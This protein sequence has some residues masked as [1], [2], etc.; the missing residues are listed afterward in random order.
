[1]IIRNKIILFNFC[2]IEINLTTVTEDDIV[3]STS[4]NLVDTGTAKDDITTGTSNNY[5]LTSNTSVNISFR[6]KFTDKIIF[7]IFFFI[8]TDHARVTK[9]NVQ[10]LSRLD[11]IV[12]GTTP[13]DD[14]ITILNLQPRQIDNIVTIATHDF[15]ITFSRSCYN[16]CIVPFFRIND[17]LTII[18]ING[19]V[20]AI[21]CNSLTTNV[22][23]QC[24]IVII[25]RGVRLVSRYTFTSILARIRNNIAIIIF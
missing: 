18:S 23:L 10:T 16:N 5:V 22:I 9:D 11:S 20:T 17:E 14:G 6:Y 13:N 7:F 8:N 25:K 15:D 4:V 2:Y 3:T 12:T 21:P 1:M 19:C 24:F